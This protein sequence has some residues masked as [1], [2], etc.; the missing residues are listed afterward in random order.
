MA[1]YF[2][3]HFYGLVVSTL[4]TIVLV[5]SQASAR[6]APESFADLAAKLLPAV[7][8][9]STTAISKQGS[10]KAPELPQFPPGSPFEDFR[11]FLDR[12][13]PQQQ[14]KST[15]LGS[16]FIIDKKGI[17]AVLTDIR[18]RGEKV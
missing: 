5:T 2:S 18:A 16:G 3:K 13:R 6:S 12:N 1:R 10:S 9:I 14:R 15:A 11:D 8:N 4:L 7:V 17:D